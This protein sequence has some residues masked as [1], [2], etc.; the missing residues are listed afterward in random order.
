MTLLRPRIVAGNWKM[1]GSRELVQGLVPAVQQALPV[2]GRCQ[3]VFCPPAVYLGELAG[4]VDHPR[5]ALGGQD[6]SAQTSGAY[7]GELGALMLAEVGCR[8]VIVGHSERR[9]YHGENSALVASKA[10][11]ALDAGLR[12]IVCIGETLAE[13]ESGQ[14]WAVLTLQLTALTDVLGHQRGGQL[15]LAYEPVWA[16]GTGVTATPEQVQEVHGQIRAWLHEQQANAS[17][18]AA[19][20]GHLPILYGG[21]VKADNAAALMAQPDVDGALVG[22]A[23]LQADEFIAICRSAE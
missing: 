18:N 9:R 20:A 3:V 10:T 23:S 16:I 5:C 8:Y 13:R 19:R 1:H 22:G 7:T 11:R 14:T 12:A 2:A 21:S 15:V 4:L 17:G 6:V